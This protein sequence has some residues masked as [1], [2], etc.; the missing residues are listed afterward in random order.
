MRKQAWKG[1]ETLGRSHGEGVAL[2][3]R[4]ALEQEQRQA[5][6]RKPSAWLHCA[7]DSFSFCLSSSWS[8]PTHTCQP[9]QKR[10][11]WA[12]TTQRP[13]HRP[14]ESHNGQAHHDLRSRPPKAHVAGSS[15][16]RCGASSLLPI[17]TLSLSQLLAI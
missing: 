17:L 9:P 13:R 12:Q 6:K 15:W 3:R 7:T 4:T 10:G 1:S 16:A 11:M 5:R 2:R 14:T 8:S